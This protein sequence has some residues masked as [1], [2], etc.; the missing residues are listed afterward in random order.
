MGLLTERGAPSWHPAP[1][2]LKV[3][4]RKASE[5]CRSKGESIEKLADSICGFQS[6]DRHYSFQYN[7]SFSGT[8][9]YSMGK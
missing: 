5:Y 9:E 7:T 2:P 4:C 6:T 1:E 3:V 8:S